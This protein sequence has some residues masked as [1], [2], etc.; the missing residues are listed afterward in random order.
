MEYIVTI[1]RRYESSIE[2]FNT[3]A[4]ALARYEE[5]KTQENEP[6]GRYQT[7]ISVSKVL[8]TDK[9]STFY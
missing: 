5:I 7:N 6:E 2:Y 4:E 8:K 1:D 3:E 9:I